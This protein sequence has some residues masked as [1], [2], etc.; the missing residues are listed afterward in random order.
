MH[1]EASTRRELAVGG[2]LAAVTARPGAALA[3][4]LLLHSSWPATAR[5]QGTTGRI[6]GRVLAEDTGKPLGGVTVT[7]SG[8]AS[9]GEQTELTDATGRYQVS[10]LLPGPGYIVRFY[11]ADVRVERPEI[12]V[13]AGR[14]LGV[15]VRMPRARTQVIRIQ[16][17]APSVEVASSSV[18]VSVGPD[19]VRQTPIRGRTYDALLSLTPGSTTDA[20]GFVFGGASGPE[21]GFVIDGLNT[22]GPAFGLIG[23]PLSL[24]FIQQTDIRVGGYG[25]ERGRATGGLVDVVTRSGGNELHGGA[26]FHLSPFSLEPQLTA[27]L[28]E[29][30]AVKARG[31][32]GPG[33]LDY[34]DHAVDFGFDVGGP[35]WKDRIWLYLGFAPSLH[36]QSYQRLIRT[37]VASTEAEAQAGGASAPAGSC[38][39]YLRSQDA[40]LCAPAS[41]AAAVT[42]PTDGRYDRRFESSSR[43]YNYIAKLT[44]RL[45][46]HN[47]L[48]VSYIGSPSTFDGVGQNP[49]NPASPA[50]SFSADPAALP[51]RDDI[52]VH[53]VVAHFVSRLWQRR[54]QLELSGGFHHEHSNV[55]PAAAGAEV[56][57]Q[58]T[59][60]LSRYEDVG[61]CLPRLV[62][63]TL[64]SPCPVSSYQSGGLGPLSERTAQRA[65]VAAGLTWFVK[66]AGTHAIKLGGDMEEIFYTDHES[67]SGG[68]DGGRFIIRPDGSVQRRQYATLAADGTTVVLLGSDDPAR[69]GFFSRTRTVNYSLYLR[70]SWS[71]SFLPG[72]TLNA[73]L[74]WEAQELKDGGGTTRIGIY[75]NLAPRVG[76]AYDFLQGGRSRFYAHYG[77]YYES[78]PLDLNNRQF[79]GAGLAIQTLRA[80]A[81]VQ[82]CPQ[83]GS[84][85][86]DAAGCRFP[87]PAPGQVFGSTGFVSPGLKGQ[88]TNEVVAGVD[89]DVGWDLVLGLAYIHRDLGR[90]ID[91]VVPDG[92]TYIIANP[93]EPTDGGAVS[94][95]RSQIDSADARARA[96]PDAASRAAL[97]A[98]RDRLSHQLALYQAAAT[99]PR[100]R[101][102]Y[103]ALQVTASRRL[104]DRFVLLA[105]YTY[106][107]TVGNY[108]G[109]YSPTTGQLNPNTSIQ[110]DLKQLM[111]NADGPLPQDRPHNF[112][113]LAAYSVPLGG[114]G[115]L[116][117]GLDFNVLSGAPIDVT[118]SHLAY[119]PGEVFIL[120]RGAGGRTPTL[121]Q[122]DLHLGWGRALGALTRVE[123]SVDL[124][125]ALDQHE[126]TAV[127]SQYTF[128]DVAPI[129]GGT[130]AQL[131]ALKTQ[132]GGAPVLNPSFGQPVSFQAPLSLRFGARLSF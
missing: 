100:P 61:P 130:P 103:N 28:G 40:A 36:T 35:L 37:R 3:L 43:L 75:D 19:L 91:D 80:P 34:L 58:R 95:L 67:Y 25:A 71:L 94:D 11:Y 98:E 120:P 125:N 127:D 41:A 64:F 68:A 7:V 121:T 66:A 88:F 8:P 79:G 123:L 97:G 42:V 93:G 53:D 55:V 73:G 32:G 96:A 48:T 76:F 46:D 92:S 20:V 115:A 113:L 107:R 63:A 18:G 39:G 1:C 99:Y 126:V 89:W 69:S 90:I 2:P 84:G 119:G 49:R 109:L 132:G 21:N 54:L 50:A 129:P 15:S 83:S 30:I 17:R 23:T 33:G 4:V 62:G 131:R 114:L 27:R 45:N 118:G 104:S 9:P 86:I 22:T 38:P 70:D 74:R 44:V 116:T 101:R 51:Y 24:E 12:E 59:S 26:W 6:E 60:P 87:A 52:E 72:F 5:G 77:R 108:A 111:V 117:L 82:L 10:E 14:T 16:E 102:D 128:S 57:D 110:Y 112:K 29:A 13:F 124:F 31:G 56:L 78:I 122:L 47:H 81:A 65:T 105:S 85:R 106:S